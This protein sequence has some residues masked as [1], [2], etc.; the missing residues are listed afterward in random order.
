MPNWSVFISS[1]L[2]NDA[3]SF[4]PKKKG[5]Y[6]YSPEY[7]S[8]NKYYLKEKL[9]IDLHV[10]HVGDCLRAQTGETINLLIEMIVKRRL[11]P[12]L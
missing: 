2:T 6:W 10:V 9:Y 4:S 7:A 3:F 12:V 8:D 1:R 5:F 11:V